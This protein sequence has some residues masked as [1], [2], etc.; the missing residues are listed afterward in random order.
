MF[1]N[2]ELTQITFIVSTT[3]LFLLFLFNLV[4]LFKLLENKI[5][6]IWWIKNER[7][8]E[9]IKKNI[10]IKDPVLTTEKKCKFWKSIN[11]DFFIIVETDINEEQIKF[12]FLKNFINRSVENDSK[13]FIYKIRNK[14]QNNKIVNLNKIINKKEKMY[15]FFVIEIKN[16]KPCFKLKFKTISKFKAFKLLKKFDNIYTEWS[17]KKMI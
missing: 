2:L 17:I 13:N 15:Y 7:S 1:L 11:S 3:S 4:S 9:K 6:W 12:P 5:W 8:F 14:Y 16:E 10:F